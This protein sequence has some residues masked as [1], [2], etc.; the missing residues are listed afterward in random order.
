[1]GWHFQGGSVL[2]KFGNDS[3]RLFEY[4]T[5][6]RCSSQWVGALKV[7]RADEIKMR[8]EVWGPSFGTKCSAESLRLPADKRV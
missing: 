4:R 1:M 8:V 7:F 2:K 6:C 3:S 5:I